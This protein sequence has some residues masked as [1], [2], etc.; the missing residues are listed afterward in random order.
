MSQ[1]SEQNDR[2]TGPG[3]DGDSNRQSGRS[4]GRRDDVRN[5]GT[6]SSRP[7]RDSDRP[8]FS[9]DSDR[10]DQPKFNR[11]A[12][13][14]RP[15]FNR[16]D[17]N[18]GPRNDGQRGGNSRDTGR[19]FRN[20]GPRNDG[21]R[22]NDRNSDQGKPRFDRNSN[23]RPSFNRDNDRSSSSR[24]SERPRFS[25]DNDRGDRPKFNRPADG[26]RPRFNRDDR[27]YRPAGAGPRPD[28]ASRPNRDDRPERPR[29]DA[30][31]PRFSSDRSRSND[32][33][34]NDRP[35]RDD[36]PSFNRDPERS[37]FSR[38]DASRDTNRESK[39]DGPARFP[40]E[41]KSTGGF[42]RPEKPAFKRV[43]GFSR[44]ADERNNFGGEDRRGEDRRGNRDEESGFTGRQRKESGDR[45]TGNFTKAPDYKLEQVRANQFAKRSRPDDRRG[46]Q[47]SDLEKG[48]RTPANDGTTRLNRFIANSGVCS[49]READELIAHG[50]ISV[51]GKVVTEM[52]YK[53]KEGDT[54]KYGTKVL[55]PER[56][57]YV[58]LNKPKDY[59]TT[60]ED[61]EERKTVMELVA[62]AG[63]FRMYP[64][65]RLDRNT[66]GLLLITNDGE[67]A[68]KLTHPSN[69]I[70]KIYQVELDK[71]IT[72]EHFEAIKKGIELEDG[73]I[74]PDAISI[75][76]PDAYV[77]GIE[78]HSGRNRIVRRI[79]E[80]FGYEV[81]KLDRTTYAGLTKKE[82]PRGKWR[83]LD[84]K[85][86]V[87]L[88]YLNS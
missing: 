75:V 45:R 61:P 69:N 86:V 21:P 56:F 78:I 29:R 3:R 30:D 74:K 5:S 65:G 4:F 9:R 67:L 47:D 32:R 54:V 68:D 83:F 84:P 49:R 51:N 73:P 85:E 87:K 63:K 34:D 40:R 38:T 28:S 79:F 55:N 42:A 36:R 19:P 60:T 88:K 52:G 71:P 57:V 53:V 80:S 23:D 70:R 10:N 15:R 27:T 41:R 37:R 16:D 43:G 22:T 82:L 31:S 20:D 11:P 14:D 33:S 77:V 13:G 24:D 46:S 26:D 81:T 25:R 59:I 1:D 44:E 50:D 7:N 2:N 64:V 17:R 39:N 48:K 12:D 66:T 72:D 18:D 58:L 8:R 6:N 62:D 35:R 76:T